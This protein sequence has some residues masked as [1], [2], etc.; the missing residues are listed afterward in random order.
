MGHHA[1]KFVRSFLFLALLYATGT[2]VFAQWQ[3]P[4]HSVPVGRGGGSSGFKFAAPGTATQPLISNGASSDPS[5]QALNLGSAGVTGNLP[6]NRLN[7]GT[8]ASASTFWRGDGQWFAPAGIGT[9]TTAGNG[10][11]LSGGGSTLGLTAPVDPTNGGTGV[12]SPTANTVPINQGASPQTNTG[13]GNWGE[14][15]GGQNGTVPAWKAGCPVL[16][17]TLTASSSASL[18]DT[19]TFTT[20]GSL[21][22]EF[23]LVFENLLP[24][25]N[26]VT[27]ILEVRSA[28]VYQTS[29]YVTSLATFSSGGLNAGGS[30]SFVSITNPSANFISSNVALGGYSGTWTVFKPVQASSAKVWTGSGAYF[31]SGGASLFS[32]M[33]SGV[34]NGTA[35]LDGF[36]LRMNTGNIASGTIKVYGVK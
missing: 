11:A 19:T 13:V 27:L 16:L 26:G 31:D 17:N 7:N 18:I 15:L 23:V 2:P 21:F 25:T 28:G 33:G 6:V 34:W 29:S 22:N 9:V 35:A 4:D 8:N 3:V 1:M 20:Y 14:C 30:T 24:A 36:R 5:F 12:I 10:L 32:T